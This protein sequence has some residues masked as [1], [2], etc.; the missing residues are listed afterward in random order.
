M[1]AH[2]CGQFYKLIKQLASRLPLFTL[3]HSEIVNFIKSNMQKFI[4]ILILLHFRISA[5]K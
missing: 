3:G 5:S 2:L 4:L 1:V